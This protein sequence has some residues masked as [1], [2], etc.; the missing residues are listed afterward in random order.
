M[1]SFPEYDDVEVGLEP[2]VQLVGGEAGPHADLVRVVA[3]IEPAV[4][5]VP[6]RLRRVHRVLV[7]PPQHTF[8]EEHQCSCNTPHRHTLTYRYLLYV[9]WY[10]TNR[11]KLGENN[12]N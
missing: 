5:A 6:P 12:T 10:D 2:G 9:S 8:K 3:A 11:L 7:H 4:E 1:T